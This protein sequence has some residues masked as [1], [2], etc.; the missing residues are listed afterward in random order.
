MIQVHMLVCENSWTIL[1]WSYFSV[2]NKFQTHIKLQAELY[3]CIFYFPYDWIANW[4]AKDSALNDSNHSVTSVC[5]KF[6]LKCNFD[7]LVLFQNA[8]NSYTFSNDLFPTLR[9]D[10]VLHADFDTWPS[11]YFSHYLLLDQSPY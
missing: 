5:C 2:R 4:K 1:L 8:I 6:F 7:L 10:F 3:F 9:C 11:T